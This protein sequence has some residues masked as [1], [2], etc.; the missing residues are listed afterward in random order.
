MTV[1]E[2]D[3][4]RAVFQEFGGSRA[5]DLVHV[6]GTLPISRGNR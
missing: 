1:L 3:L 4:E 5:A 6:V 2:L